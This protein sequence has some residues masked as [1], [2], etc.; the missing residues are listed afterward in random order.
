MDNKLT[1]SHCSS[2]RNLSER[3]IYH[4][5]QS[6]TGNA[7]IGLRASFLLVV[8]LL[9]VGVSLFGLPSQPLPL[10][11]AATVTT[12]VASS[13]VIV[14]KP[15]CQAVNKN[16][17]CYNFVRGS[18]IY[19]PKNAFCSYFHCVSDFWK[20]VRGYV[21]ECGN[22]EYSHSGGIRGVC[23]RDKKVWRT[24]YSH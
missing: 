13:P 6:G 18:L 15:K 17:W 10:V 3:N 1:L 12:S 20:A 19:R 16:P 4:F 21:V 14:T 23:S 9:A 2:T 5:E 24:L 11:S 22:G 8:T 7:K